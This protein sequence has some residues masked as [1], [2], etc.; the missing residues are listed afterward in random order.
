ML[1]ADVSLA[2]AAAAGPRPL[3]RLRDVHLSFGATPV[4]KGID[5]DVFRGQAVSIIGP[6]GSGKSTIL[7]CITGLLRPQ[8]GEIEVDGTR[9]DQLASERDEIELRKRVGFVFQQYNLFPHLS[10]LDNLLVAPVRILGRDKA[11]ATRTAYDLLKKVRLE[12]KAHAYPG[13]LSGGQQQRVAIA[14]ALAMQPDLILFDEVTSA[15]D[16]ET[17]GEVLT[18]IRDLVRDGMTC[19]LV[20]HE[21]RFAEEVSDAVYFTEA[22]VIVEHGPAN[23]LFRAPVSPRTREFLAHTPSAP[24]TAHAAAPR[25]P[26]ALDLRHFA[27]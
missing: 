8:Y 23:A 11:D 16:P 25:T 2:P 21:M 15:L 20:T 17:V 3:V 1:S 18:V 24:E 13:E 7:R 27:I 6:S 19:V 14:R 4:L 22:G 26:L 9:V 10:V 5:L 12:N